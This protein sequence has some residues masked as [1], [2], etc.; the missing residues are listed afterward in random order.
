MSS[1]LKLGVAV[2]GRGDPKVVEELAVRAD[3]LGYDSFLIT[4][5][6]M[7]PRGSSTIDA[8]AFIP[9][10]AARTSKI[11]LGTCV[12]PLPFR[13]PAVLAKTVATCDHLSNGRVI[14]GAGF[15]WYEPEFAA[16]SKWESPGERV[17][18]SEEAIQLMMRLWTE[19]E[20]VDFHGRFVSARG[21]VVEPKPVQRPCPLVLW[22]G[23]RRASLRMAGRYA[24]GWIPV[25]PRWYEDDYPSAEDYGKMRES[26]ES[27][28]N[29]PQRGSAGFRYTNIIGV[30]DVKTLG[31]DVGAYASEGLNFVTIGI[32]ADELKG[33]D[34]GARLE[35][36]ASSL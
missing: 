3:E 4:D 17:A 36:I 33:G 30:A 6:F 32:P 26:I 7:T 24:G 31:R 2:S 19:D 27:E 18:H 13:N 34:L 28:V 22:G 29:R 35:E 1:G 9:Y 14:L 10:L 5:H 15:G 25:G 8:W 20:P 12:T 21:A 16:F 23:H 11:R